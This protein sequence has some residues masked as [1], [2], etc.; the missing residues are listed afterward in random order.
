MFKL[1]NPVFSLEDAVAMAKR[2][3][4]TFEH[5]GNLRNE[6][7]ILQWIKRRGYAHVKLCFKANGK[8]HSERMWVRVTEYHPNANVHSGELD[9]DPIN[10]EQA[11]MFALYRG[12]MPS[13]DFDNKLKSGDVIE[14]KL[15]NVY[16]IM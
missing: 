8:D 3:P 13:H 7:E 11:A 14:F 5:N 15:K 2:H 10:E 1:E 9:N 16:N 12:V 6:S 4:E